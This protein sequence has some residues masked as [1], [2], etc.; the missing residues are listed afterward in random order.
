MIHPFRVY[1]LKALVYLQSCVSITIINFRTLYYPTN[2]LYTTPTI[3]NACSSLPPCPALP[4]PRQPL[5]YILCI[6]ICLF[7]TF[8]INGIVQYGHFVADLITQ[9][10]VSKF[11][12]CCEVLVLDSFS[13]LNNIPLHGYIPHLSFHS[14]VD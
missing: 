11:H 2:K 13:L 10:N 12:L 5:I 14:S 7:R 3:L 6:Q 1:N 9:H 4:S 8:H